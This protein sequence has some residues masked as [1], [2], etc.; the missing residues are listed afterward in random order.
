MQL[1]SYWRSS[2]AY[3]V[4]IA[5][6]L[7]QID[8][9]LI[10]VNLAPGQDQQL[11]AAYR[12]QNPQMLVPMLIDGDV[13]ITQSLA[14]CEY[15]DAEHP[16]P[17]LVD[18]DAARQAEI[19]S[20]ALLVACEI[21]PLNNLRVLKYLKDPG[22]LSQDQVDAWYRH[23]IASGFEALETRLAAQPGPWACG[24]EPGLVDCVLIPQLY[25]AHRFDCPLDSYPRIRQIEALSL[26]HPA[27]IA[28]HPDNQADKP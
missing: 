20:L 3:R 14:I 7:K 26:D 28:A 18:G 5:L 6:N 23:W 16:E 17:A 8:H 22:G 2:S 9:E 21:Q 1:Y 11:S 25:N 12:A 19:R 4:R 10:P 24:P 27:F 15:L 13:R